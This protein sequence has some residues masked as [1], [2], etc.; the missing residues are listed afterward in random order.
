MTFSIDNIRA[1]LKLGGARP[2]LFKVLLN[3][4]FD[5]NLTSIGSVLVQA[6]ELPASTIGAIEVPYMGR[7]IRVAGDR[8]FEPWR[9]SV[10]NDEDF[11]IR[12]S[13][14]TWHNQVNSL[15]GNLNTT[16][17]S[18]PGNYKQNADV[19]QYGKADDQNPIRVY[20]MYGIFPTDISSIDLDWNA[21]NTLETFNVTLSFDWFEV[22]SGSTGLLA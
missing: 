15:S 18:A 11:A 14:E 9:I 22:V 16:G 19:L 17:G 10:M 7:K 5:T 13:F 8:T 4:P 2:T 6:T 20:R 3:N 12:H 21:T 1:G